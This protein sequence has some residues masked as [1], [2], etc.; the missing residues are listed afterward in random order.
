VQTLAGKRVLITGAASGIGK[1]MAQRFAAERAN[2]VL[3]D[4]NEPQLLATASELERT[5]VNVHSYKLD[6]TDGPG[7]LALRERIH[8]DTGGPID[9]LVNNAGLVFGGKFL[10]VPLEKHMLTYRVNIESLVAFTHAFLGDLIGRPDAHV[11]N[12][13]SASGFVGLPLGSTYASSKW[14]VIGFSESLALELD[15]LGHRHVHVTAACPSYVT[16]GLF[17]GAKAPLFTSLLTAEKV[18]DKVVR[19]VL[20]NR[21]YVKTP[22]LIA[23]TPMLKGL[24]P[25]K[26]FYLVASL[27]GVNT[28]MTQWKGRGEKA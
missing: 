19:A 5:G 16:T 21:M 12:T 13:A 17:D 23:M 14:A 6:V 8:R 24:L 20:G 22:W 2:L 3:V 15:R 26:M 18:A 11:V 10:E 1:A 28:S 9:V 27:L 25:F 4:L 7:I